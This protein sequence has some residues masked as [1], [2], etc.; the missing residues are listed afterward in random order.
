[1]SGLRLELSPSRGLA[2]LIV[3]FHAAAGLSVFAVLPG[4]AGGMLAAALMALGIA[5]AWNRALLRSAG[6]VRS[7]ELKSGDP[8]TLGSNPQ[9]QP[10]EIALNLASG[11]RIVAETAERRYVTR[12]V[13][14]LPLRRPRR[15]ILVTRDMLAPASFRALRLWA[16][17]GRLPGVATKQ[18]PA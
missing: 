9:R 16:L 2:W 18:L 14:A 12:F 3:A 1:L 10:P 13:V 17:W 8:Q 11:A 5:A 15:T 7:I 6:S 4:V